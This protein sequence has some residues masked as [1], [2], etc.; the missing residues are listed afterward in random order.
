MLDKIQKIEDSTESFEE[1][2]EILSNSYEASFKSKDEENTNRRLNGIY[3]TPYKLSQLIVKKTIEKDKN[4]LE[5]TFFEPCLGLGSFVFAYLE[6]ILKDAGEITYSLLAKIE[7]NIYVA[8]LDETAINL[9]VLVYKIFLKRKYNYEYP[10]LHTNFNISIESLIYSRKIEELSLE[11]SFGSYVPKFDYIMTNPP[12]FVLRYVDRKW[13]S[14]DEKNIIKG[15]INQISSIIKSKK[16]NFSKGKNLNIYEVFMEEIFE[17]YSKNDTKIGLLIPYSFLT[18]KST[19]KMRKNILRNYMVKVVQPINENTDF[20]PVGQSMTIFI[21]D[22]KTSNMK[23]KLYPWIT[24]EEDLENVTFSIVDTHIF[25]QISD[26]CIFLN[27]DNK[28]LKLLEKIHQYHKL[29]HIPYIVNRRGEIDSTKY[30]NNIKEFPTENTLNLT[31]GK[32]LNIYKFAI[33]SSNVL[34]DLESPVRKLYPKF[35]IACN[36]ISNLK[37]QDRLKFCI[38]ENTFLAN[39]CNYIFCE[40]E[41]S[42]EITYYLM[43]LMN[44]SLMEWRFR[45]TNGNNHVSNY[46]LDELPLNLEKDELYYKIVKKFL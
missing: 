27:L 22:K 8:E 31:K 18:N 32:D 11:K 16:Y 28:G 14:E 20:Y 12:Y 10:E 24:K 34:L 33:P 21:I 5:K 30:K 9:F 36:Q 2:F 39:S 17:N 19:S 1:F 45:V 35:R 29:K 42:K 4:L 15:K 41:H 38:A 13:Y 3:H 46:E 7:K 37:S 23:T 44:S 26:D 6:E 40:G 43:A 25:E